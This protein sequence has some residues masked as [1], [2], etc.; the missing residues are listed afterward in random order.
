MVNKM[1]VSRE[2]CQAINKIMSDKLDTLSEDVK[3]VAIKVAELP[4]LMADKFDNRYASK[5]TEQ[6]VDRVMWLVITAVV[7]AGL[8]VVL[9]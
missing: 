4:E 5:K 8:A 7:I 2:E 3:D 6:A 1:S 9:K